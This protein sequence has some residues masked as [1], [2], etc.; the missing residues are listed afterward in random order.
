MEPALDPAQ[1]GPSPPQLPADGDAPSCAPT[2]EQRQGVTAR[3]PALAPAGGAGG[4]ADPPAG[5]DQGDPHQ[6]L[7][8]QGV[9]RRGDR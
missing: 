6:A 8:L 3:P 9:D 2:L 4:G 1:V 5:A 7:R